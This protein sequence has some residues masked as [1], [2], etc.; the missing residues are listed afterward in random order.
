MANN[1]KYDPNFTKGVI[2]TTGEKASPRTKQI[3]A[4]FF[5]HLHDFIREVE[6]T[7]DEWMNAVHWVNRVGQISTPTRNESHRISDITG[8]ES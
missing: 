1:H 4:S 8:I 2:G 5:T 6:L 7:P 3:F